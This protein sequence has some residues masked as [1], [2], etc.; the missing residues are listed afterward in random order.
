MCKGRSRSCIIQAARCRQ[1]QE[2]WG[3]T[4]FAVA[5][6]CY[7]EHAHGSIQAPEGNPLVEVM[8]PVTMLGRRAIAA[9]RGDEERD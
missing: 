3:S 5:A 2:V 1:G 9:A 6:Q 4:S 7:G 8:T